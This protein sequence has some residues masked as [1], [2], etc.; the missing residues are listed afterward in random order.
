MEPNAKGDKWM[1]SDKPI[2]G[3]IVIL[4]LYVDHF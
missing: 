2:D 4:T 1:Y 3:N